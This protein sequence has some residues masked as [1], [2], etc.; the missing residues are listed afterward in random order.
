MDQ[1]ESDKGTFGEINTVQIN[2][3]T[4]EV[5]QVEFEDET[6]FFVSRS[7]QVVCMIMQNEKHVWEPDCDIS[8][9]LFGQMIEYIYKRYS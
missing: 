5:Q 1:Q 2:N 4:Y 7:G 6:F 3:E 9:E 8:E